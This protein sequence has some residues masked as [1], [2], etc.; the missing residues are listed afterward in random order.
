MP[1]PPTKTPVIVAY[2]SYGGRLTELSV[3]TAIEATL[4]QDARV[5][6]IRRVPAHRG[7][8]HGDRHP[9]RGDHRRGALSDPDRGDRDRQDRD[10]GMDDRAGWQAG[11]RDRAQQDPG[12]AAVQRVPGILPLQRRRVLSLLLRI[13]PD[14]GVRTLS[15]TGHSDRQ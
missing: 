5:Q 3:T 15:G 14:R 7:P 10:D 8:A 4:G 11:A 6:N 12:G 2:A 9:R 1:R 13:L